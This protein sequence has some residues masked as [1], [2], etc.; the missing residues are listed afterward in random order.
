MH[1]GLRTLDQLA[2]GTHAVVHH[3]GCDRPVARRLME[4]GLLP[5]TAIETVRRAPLGDPLEIRLRGYLLSIRL[6]DAALIQLVPE[7]RSD[8]LD[9]VGAPAET[10][11]DSGFQFG[12]C[13]NRPSASTDRTPTVLLAGNAN[14][15]KTTIFNALTGARAQVSNY[16]GVTVT[17]SS[18]RITLPGGSPVELV[19]LPGTYSLSANAP[20]EQVA[21]DEVL[22]RRGDPPDAVV[23][24][25]DAGAVERGLYLGLQIVETGVP[26]VVALNMIDEA[27]AAGADF[28]AERLGQWL[29]ATVVPTVASRG[30]G[31][32]ELREAIETTL[33]RGPRT[34]PAKLEFPAGAEQDV[35]S[36]TETLA[37][38]NFGKTPAVQRAWAVWS[39]LSLEHADDDDAATGL[40]EP[41]RREVRATHDRATQ[42]KRNLHQEIIA[43]RYRWI[44]TV[45]ADVRTQAR[46][47]TRRWTERLDGILIHRVYGVVVF[48]VVM[49]VLFEA[50]F[51]WSEPF[52]GAIEGATGWLQ[53]MVATS[54]PPGVLNDLLIDGVIAGVGNVVVFVPQIAML[55]FFIAL[56][57]DLGYLARVAFVI[58]RLMGRVGLHGKA[59]VPMLS[60]FAC[61][62]PAVMATRTIES[63]RDRLITMLTLPMVSCSARLPV[64]ALVTAVVFAGEPRV[65][66]LL[67]VGALVL[68][69]MYT[70]SV[71]ATLGAAAVLRRTVLTGPRLPLVL[72]LPP[73]RVPVWRSV[74]LVTW[75]RVRK[76]LED[77]GTIILTMTIIL[78]A[79]LSF[80]HSAEIDTQYAASRADVL[81]TTP[82]A[83]QE[84]ALAELDGRLASEQLRY[85]V[86]GRMGRLIEPVLEPLGFDWRI[87]VG[88]LGAFAAREVFVST[89]GIVFGI[90]AADEESV[91]LRSSL[92][93]A[94]RDDGSRLM[95]PLAGVSLMVFFVLA[96]QCMST[97]VVVRKEAGGWGWPVFMFSYMS[98]LAYVASLAVY[99]VGSLLGWGNV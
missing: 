12:A 30:R 67:S 22:G 11:Q 36:V 15:G 88:I 68:F 29:G 42:A 13:P 21:A 35:A 43:A 7:G 40:P 83:D 44:E 49:A 3:V 9:E 8:L 69:S 32:A 75:R 66:G 96:C 56:L 4:M 79:L 46:P 93:N 45:A 78:W 25:V 95:T 18:R 65:L 53:S 48:A 70:L 98:V 81:A 55:F 1:Q 72:E 33:T 39:L 59:F 28:D 63:R 50:L 80:P 71:A 76:F 24:V 64:Y 2:I 77:A 10:Q 47:D 51:T 89:L 57:E 82:A 19:D 74:A 14:S 91:G 27:S 90:E 97:I 92:Q 23:V 60:G 37:V 5:G 61:A 26:V 85:S 38:T 31:L 62:I 6:A 34:D 20:D 52:I 54:L 99:Q 87:G 16:P 94:T 17:R 86:G 84:A 58:D 41:V 73:Y